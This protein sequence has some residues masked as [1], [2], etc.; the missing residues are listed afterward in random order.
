MSQEKN[1]NL[2]LSCPHCGAMDQ[3]LGSR[4][5]GCGRLIA[6]GIP[7]WATRGPRQGIF[8]RHGLIFMTQNKW[9]S[10]ALFVIVMGAL[11]WHNYHIVP[12]PVS[13]LLN[14][15][16]TDLSSQ[17]VPG[18][19]A[20]PGVDYERT[21]YVPNPPSLPQGNLLWS[22]EEGLVEGQSLPAV[23]DSTVYV[24]GR[25]EFM[26]LDANTGETQWHREM[27]GLVNSSP[28]VAG[29]SV[30][31]GSTDTKLWV[32]D[33]DTGETRWT[34]KTNNYISSS[35][36]IANGFVFI[37][38]GDKY[39]HALDAATGKKF[40]EFRTEE[41]ITAPPSLHNGVLYFASQDNSLYSVN[42]RTGESRMQFRTRG[43]A[44][45]EP[46][47]I[48]H[49]LAYMIS[50]NDILTAKAGIREV[51]GRWA[52]ERIWRI[53]WVRW[54]APIPTPPPQQG[55][56]WR[57]EPPDS[58]FITSSPA[59]TEDLMYVGDSE[60]VLRAME[61]T[62]PEE[63]WAFQGEGAIRGSPIVAGHM[64]YFATT[65]GMVYGVNRDTRE[66]VWSLDVGAPVL[67]AP[68]LA[69]GKLFIRTED[70][71]VHAIG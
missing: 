32:F 59:F 67:L 23:V 8:G 65:A 53:L 64:V 54:G 21:N 39:L 51:P 33:K 60:G 17:S 29:D 18:Q 38:S 20:M 43:V 50:A 56:S 25:F 57:W 9:L 11:V 16:S 45:F 28:A 4:C 66:E 3:G 10:I 19:W 41:L 47:V 24:G 30:Y 12:N 35:P 52:R 55:T 27:P 70:G 15:P 42:Y 1:S 69:E 31:V 5:E 14:R 2:V 34:F 13:L 7:D 44:S 63:V 22:T 6:E 36:L 71:R 61:P 49:G 62:T 68:A 40:W 58:A 46:P 37:G 48:A 26:A